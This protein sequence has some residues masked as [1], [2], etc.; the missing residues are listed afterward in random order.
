MTPKREDRQRIMGNGQWATGNGQKTIPVAGS[1][2]P[3]PLFLVV[4]LAAVVAFG[5]A[6][7]ERTRCYSAKQR[8]FAAKHEPEP[9]VCPGLG[10]LIMS[11]GDEEKP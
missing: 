10:L 6:G 3:I 11:N 7:C 9:P 4:I 8:C 5:A 1:L 2:F